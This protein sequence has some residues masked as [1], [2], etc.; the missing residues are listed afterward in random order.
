MRRALVERFK[1][2]EVSRL[3]YFHCDHFE[4]WA[5]IDGR[6][7]VDPRHAEDLQAFTD[8]RAG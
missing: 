6:R 8:D 3:V 4:P 7:A 2:R 5:A 1:S